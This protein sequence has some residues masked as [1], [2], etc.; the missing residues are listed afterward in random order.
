MRK[1]GLCCRPVSVR[2]S[3]RHVRVLHPDQWYFS[4]CNNY[5]N[6]N[7]LT[8]VNENE[9]DVDF[10]NENNIKIKMMSYKTYKNENVIKENKK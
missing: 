1:R 10:Q 8:V 4:N 2:L 9:N 6:G 3:V 5:E 7:T